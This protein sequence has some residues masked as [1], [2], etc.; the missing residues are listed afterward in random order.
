M[1][2]RTGL[3]LGERRPLSNRT[4]GGSAQVICDRVVEPGGSAPGFT[5]MS[6]I[7]GGLKQRD[8]CQCRLLPAWMAI[9]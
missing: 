5:P 2:F 9:R 6:R 8:T 7:L 3:L 1:K 4:E